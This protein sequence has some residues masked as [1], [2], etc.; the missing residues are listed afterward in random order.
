MSNAVLPPNAISQ[1]VHIANIY[2][3]AAVARSSGD[4]RPTITTEM[5]C[6]EFCSVYA[7]ITG[8]EPFNKILNSFNTAFHGD[9][10]SLRG[11]RSSWISPFSGFSGCLES[12]VLLGNSADLSSGRVSAEEAS[13]DLGLRR[14]LGSHE[15]AGP[16]SSIVAK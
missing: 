4:L 9:F 1:P 12:F 16:V 13:G 10:D 6:S 15:C 8:M 11:S 5:V 14:K 7:K 3:K 2:A